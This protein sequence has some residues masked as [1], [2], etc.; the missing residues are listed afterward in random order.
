MS[1]KEKWFLAG[2]IQIESGQVLICDAGNISTNLKELQAEVNN[3]GRFEFLCTQITDNLGVISSTGIGDGMY[4]VEVL[5]S[6]ESG[7]GRRVHELRIRFIDPEGM[8]SIGED[9]SGKQGVLM[10]ESVM[11]NPKT[12]DLDTL[13]VEPLGSKSDNKPRRKK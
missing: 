2:Q 13:R 9:D 7:W 3:P 8:Y 11:E 5:I 10:D 4:D 6:E 12:I 1:Q